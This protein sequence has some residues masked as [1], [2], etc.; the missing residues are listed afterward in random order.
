MP[1]SHSE[2]SWSLELLESGDVSLLSSGAI[3]RTTASGARGAALQR[4]AS[5]STLQPVFRCPLHG[6]VMKR[7]WDFDAV[8]TT[9]TTRIE[10]A[11]VS[12]I[13]KLQILSNPTT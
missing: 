9:A 5:A 3:C 6:S 10:P 2:G 4:S 11:T 1:I 8:A 13:S 7:L 12:R